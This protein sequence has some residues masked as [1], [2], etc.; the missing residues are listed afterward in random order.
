[1]IFWGGTFFAFSAIF[2]AEIFDKNA[3]RDKKTAAMEKR[4]GKTGQV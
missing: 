2:R 4:D 1:L 3:W